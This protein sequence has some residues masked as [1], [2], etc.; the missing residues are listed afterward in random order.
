MQMWKEATHQVGS[1]HPSL[2]GV[3]LNSLPEEEGKT[4]RAQN[5]LSQISLTLIFILFVYFV[6]ERLEEK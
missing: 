6:M 5:I 3:S 2:L 4:L 1:S